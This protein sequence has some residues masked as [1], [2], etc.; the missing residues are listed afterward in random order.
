MVNSK[1]QNPDNTYYRPELDD[2]NFIPS[3]GVI[4]RY[5]YDSNGRL[6]GTIPPQQYLR[7]HVPDDNI[8]N[9]ETSNYILIYV[10]FIGLIGFI[11]YKKITKNETNKKIYY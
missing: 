1:A 5:Y 8:S 3:Q 2:I 9:V 11:I 6:Q 4:P 10:F 7:S